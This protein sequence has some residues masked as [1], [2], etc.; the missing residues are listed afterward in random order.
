MAAPAWGWPVSS[1]T[2][3]EQLTVLEED[4]WLPRAQAHRDQVTPLIEERLTRR[5]RGQ[6]NAV[7]DF[8]FEYYPYSP[9]KLATWHAGTGFAL[10][11]SRAKDYLSLTGYREVDGLVMLDPAWLDARRARL[12]TTVRILRGTAGRPPGIG[13]FALHEW[14]MTYRLTQ[15]EVRHTYL[16]LRL[17]PDEIA[18]TVD[19]IGLRCTHI[20]AFRFFTPDAV[21]LNATTPTRDAQPENEQPGCLHAAMDLYKYAFWHSPFVPSDLVLAC[22]RNAA[23]ARELDMRA[24]PYDVTP[25]GLAPIR[26][27]TPD[28]RREY[29]D[30]QR[31]MME[32][33]AP[34]RARLLGALEALARGD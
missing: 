24:S 33:T 15:D 13:C 7:E 16:P 6:K 27:E 14:A 5:E 9:N 28:G 26:V 21:P 10:T 29:A 23:L 17:S 22:F 25:F 3:I 34:L 12:D 20:D 19:E 1:S 18:A 8:L 32:R 4:E 11:G 30:E 31:R 2:T